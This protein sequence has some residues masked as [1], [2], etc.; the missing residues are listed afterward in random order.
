MKTDELNR[1][2]MWLCRCWYVASWHTYSYN[3]CTRAMCYV[4]LLCIIIYMVIRSTILSHLYLFRIICNLCTLS[5]RRSS[6]DLRDH[7]MTMMRYISRWFF[8]H[9]TQR[10]FKE[11]YSTDSCHGTL[12]KRLMHE[13]MQRWFPLH[14]NFLSIFV[15]EISCLLSML[16]S[17]VQW[18]DKNEQFSTDSTTFV[19]C[20][21]NFPI[22][23]N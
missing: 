15:M 23:N 10:Y 2:K 9:F 14:H 1:G 21:L 16:Y 22:L 17:R 4:L 5:G 20:I 13:T 6:V 3:M 18:Y 8:C 7:A 19:C 12:V 11:I